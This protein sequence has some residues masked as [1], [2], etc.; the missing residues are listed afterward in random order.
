MALPYNRWNGHMMLGD[1]N[2]IGR[3]CCCHDWPPN[4]EISDCLLCDPPVLPIKLWARAQIAGFEGTWRT[5]RVVFPG[6]LC[7]HFIVD[8]SADLACLNT[9]WWGM[10]NTP[11]SGCGWGNSN[12]LEAGAI[13]AWEACAAYLPECVPICHASPWYP[14]LSVW[15][16]ATTGY[17]SVNARILWSQDNDSEQ[18]ITPYTQW[19][20]V[21]TGDPCDHDWVN[22]GFPMALPDVVVD[23]LPTE[24]ATGP[25]DG[26]GDP[27]SNNDILADYVCGTCVVDFPSTSPPTTDIC[28]P[29]WLR[30]WTNCS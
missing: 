24:W 17:F 18:S 13:S 30:N 8:L 10:F 29:A 2:H 27:S 15:I 23:S 11:G 9:A 22:D 21:I 1:G 7:P 14:D 20:R 3:E 4:E 25:Y 26:C 5:Q 28:V 19:Q 16:E 12:A 6:G